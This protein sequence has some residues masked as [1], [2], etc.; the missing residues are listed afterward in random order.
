MAVPSTKTQT[1]PE[2]E[3]KRVYDPLAIPKRNFT[4]LL[5]WLFVGFLF[6]ILYVAIMF[7]ALAYGMLVLLPLI[8]FLRPEAVPQKKKNM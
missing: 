6:I 8:A 5:A 7:N 2:D 1:L 4:I 3:E